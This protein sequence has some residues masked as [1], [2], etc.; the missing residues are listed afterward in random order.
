ML[1]WLACLSFLRFIARDEK[2]QIVG[3]HSVYQ[4]TH[5]S[6]NS[7]GT[8]DL[9]DQDSNRTITIVFIGN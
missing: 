7:D 2:H 1:C 4:S 6:D 9:L 8:F 5:N 3:N